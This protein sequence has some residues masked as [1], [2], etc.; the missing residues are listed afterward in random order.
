[1]KCPLCLGEATLF[2]KNT[3][4]CE[5][6]HTFFETEKEPEDNEELA[7]KISNPLYK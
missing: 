3:Y 6:C 2:Y 7:K 5:P 4:K 1:M